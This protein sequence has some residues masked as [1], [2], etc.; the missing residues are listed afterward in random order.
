MTVTQ[1]AQAVG[2]QQT[3]YFTK[4]LKNITKLLL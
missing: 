2:Y 4:N 1:I 3:S